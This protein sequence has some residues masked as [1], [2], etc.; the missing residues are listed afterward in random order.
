MARKIY[1]SDENRKNERRLAK[2]W[3]RLFN[4]E[5][6][7][8]PFSYFLDFVCERDGKI[9]HI[10]EVRKRNINIADHD[11]HMIS[12]KKVQHAKELTDVLGVPCYL[13]FE[14]KDG[15]YYIDMA[16]QP[17]YYNKWGRMTKESWRGD[18][19]DIEIMA[20]WSKDRFIKL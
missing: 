3:E 19:A 11:T 5:C 9:I 10:L 13:L 2:A 15:C 1:E 4:V 6:S 20:H 14:Y 12:M 16:Q 17:D 8:L 18:S 7:K